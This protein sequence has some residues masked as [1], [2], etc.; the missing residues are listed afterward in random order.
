MS[1]CPELL[2]RVMIQLIIIMEVPCRRPRSADENRP[3]QLIA[4]LVGGV[5]LGPTGRPGAPYFKGRQWVSKTSRRPIERSGR[6]TLPAY[7]GNATCNSKL[8]QM[9]KR[10]ANVPRK[11]ISEQET[12]A[13][14]PGSERLQAV[15][16]I[17]LNPSRSLIHKIN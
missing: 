5:D 17:L 16:A 10:V 2:P 9:Q 8:S 6:N 14:T 11:A 1:A 4:W 3:T 15:P 12:V 7:S 13:A